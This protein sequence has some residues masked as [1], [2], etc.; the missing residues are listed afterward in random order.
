MT[1]WSDW[2]NDEKLENA[3]VSLV[4]TNLKHKKYSFQS[5]GISL[6]TN[7]VYEHLIVGFGIL[8]DIGLLT[9]LILFGSSISPFENFI[10]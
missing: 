3:L 6:I 9:F 2:K 8:I 1:S 10:N 7:R 5:A 4:A